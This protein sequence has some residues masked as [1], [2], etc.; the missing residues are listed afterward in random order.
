MTRRV[1]LV[2]ATRRSADVRGGAS[3]SV[4][5]RGAA[6]QTAA[7]LMS[8]LSTALPTARLLDRK[9]AR[10]SAEALLLHV[11]RDYSSAKSDCAGGEGDWR[12]ARGGA[13]PANSAVEPACDGRSATNDEDC[14]A[15]AECGTRDAAICRAMA[16]REKASRASPDAN[17]RRASGGG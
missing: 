15:G 11:P 9:T 1:D 12:W 5:L 14:D 6:S 16:V 8:A 13:R 2:S 7:L 10:T 3:G 17:K 4:G